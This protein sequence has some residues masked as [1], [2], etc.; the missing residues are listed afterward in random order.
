VFYWQ[1]RT[2]FLWKFYTELEYL[3]IV[4]I[5]LY[6]QWYHNFYC[7][8]T[9]GIYFI[10]R[11]ISYLLIASPPSFTNYPA[12]RGH[13]FTSTLLNASCIYKLS[14]TPW[15]YHYIHTTKC[16]LHLQTKLRRYFF[17]RLLRCNACIVFSPS[18]LSHLV[19]W[20]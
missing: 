8:I 19:V 15:T 9:C 11:K 2:V 17:Q 10:P 4:S 6:I 13:I 3:C 20:M 16:L 7:F 12:P 1:I 14:C 18:N 5:K